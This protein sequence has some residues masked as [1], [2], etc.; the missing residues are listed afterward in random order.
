MIVQQILN[1]KGGGDVFTVD[2]ATPI[3]EVTK[4]LRKNVSAA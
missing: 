3:S 2:P 1:S 4:S